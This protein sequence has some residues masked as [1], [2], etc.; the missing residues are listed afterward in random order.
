[1]KKLLSLMLCIVFVCCTLV[2]C[3]QDIIGEYLENYNTNQITDDK[4]EKLNFYIITGDETSAEAKITVPQNI[5]AY[6]KEKYEIELNIVYCTAAEYETTLTG[7]M[8]KTNEAERPD[9][10]L[11]NSKD[12]FMELYTGLVPL[13]D[14][15]NHRD[16]KKINTIVD[17]TLL[18]ASSV[19]YSDKGVATYYTVPNNH[20]VG[21]YKY[22]VI[23]KSMARDTLHFSNEEIATMTTEES[24]EELVAA[25]SAYYS[26]DSCNSA[27]TEEEFVAQYVKVVSGSYADKTL[28]EY[29]V[30]NAGEIKDGDSTVNF[31]NIN[32]YPNATAEEAFSSA[33]AIVKHLDDGDNN[34]EEKQAALDKHYNKCMKIIYA[35]NTDAQLKNMLQYG[36]VGTNYRFIKN[37]KNENTNYIT[38]E[39]GAE[40][41]Y[42]MNPVHTGN[43]FISYYCEELGWNETVHNNILKQ[44]ADAK[45]P[46]Q[47]LA[48]EL[49]TFFTGTKTVDQYSVFDCPKFGSVYSDIVFTW[50]SSNPDLAIIAEDGTLTFANPESD[51]T[52]TITATLECAGATETLE[53]KFKVTVA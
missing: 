38:L 42:Q 7:A 5:N 13:N 15:Y 16:Y 40:V 28:L 39:K 20:V 1:M 32:S 35:L 24:L 51:T 45:T 36:Y 29:D 33:F 3:G 43:L 47:K 44:N 52:V 53:F 17:K 50:T 11:I 46:A 9:I 19:I 18:A 37:H 25:I 48:A 27:L 30:T 34:T 26:S 12:M 2:G 21:E 14:F 49:D 4:I 10:I 31:V 41:V 23:D 8:N 6:L 22:V